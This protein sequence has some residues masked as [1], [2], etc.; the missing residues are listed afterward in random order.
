MKK[1]KN[2]PFVQMSFPESKHWKKNAIIKTISLSKKEIVLKYVIM[3]RTVSNVTDDYWN[4]QIKNWN[5]NKNQ[6]YFTVCST[7]LPW[8]V[9]VF[10]TA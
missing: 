6:H 8:Q 9:S 3:P 7:A 10:A 5:L 4:K 2:L 1:S